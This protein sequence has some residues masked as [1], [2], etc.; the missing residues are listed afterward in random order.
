[1]NF[2]TSSEMSPTWLARSIA[3]QREPSRN[4]CAGNWKDDSV[5]LKPWSYTESSTQPGLQDF[6][7]ATPGAHAAGT[8]DAGVDTAASRLNADAQAF[9]PVHPASLV[10]W[11][12]ETPDHTQKLPKV[13]IR[14]FL[15]PHLF[16]GDVDTCLS[17]IASQLRDAPVPDTNAQT[18]RQRM[19]VTSAVKKTLQLLPHTRASDALVAQLLRHFSLP[20]PGDVVNRT[21]ILYALSSHFGDTASTMKVNFHGIRNME[22]FQEMVDRVVAEW[23][24]SEKKFLH[25]HAD[26][27]RLEPTRLAMLRNDYVCSKQREGDS[28]AF[29][30]DHTVQTHRSRGDSQAASADDAREHGV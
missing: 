28:L 20:V 18:H 2:N 25:V 13:L 26:Q 16:S 10:D 29:S 6:P 24:A 17:T 1:M 15:E 8:F 12:S 7:Q 9:N 14:R 4:W 23:A 19:R 5:E 30:K 27:D 3:G 11:V 21:D 22:L